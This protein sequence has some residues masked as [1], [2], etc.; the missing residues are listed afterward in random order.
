LLLQFTPFFLF[1]SLHP[2]HLHRILPA[3]SFSFMEAAVRFRPRGRTKAPDCH[4]SVLWEEK[5]RRGILW[6]N[7]PRLVH[8]KAFRTKLQA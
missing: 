1:Q 7:I 3:L 8:D 4:D 5:K 6:K 2:I